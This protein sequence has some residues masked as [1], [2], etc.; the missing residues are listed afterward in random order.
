MSQSLL[1]A[2]ESGD[3]EKLKQR[4]SAGDDIE[5]RHKGTG[6]TALLYAVINGHKDAVKLLLEKGADSTAS[7]KAVGHD[8]LLWAIQQGHE[9]LVD[10]FLGRGADPNHVPE[11]SFLGRTPLMIAAQRGNFAIAKQLLAAGANPGLL[12]RQG[13]SALALA[14]EAKHDEMAA[15]LRTIPGAAP[16]LPREPDTILWPD[17][18]EVVTNPLPDDTSPI[19]IVRGY[20]LAM[21]HWETSAYQEMKKARENG[22]HFDFDPCIE[23]VRAIRGRYGTAKKRVYER[24]SVGFPSEFNADLLLLAEE[25]PSAGKCTVLTRYPK[26]AQPI[27]RNTEILFMLLKKQGQWRIDSIKNRSIGAQEWRQV[28]L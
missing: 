21:Y 7:C 17:I 3:M 5:F 12:D 18:D 6:R 9:D 8:S 16:A 19:Q 22:S 11:N 24:S 25:Y 14:E 23:K 1:R 10:L 26:N 2:A 28:I 20:I 27:Q 4:L 15:F 13:K